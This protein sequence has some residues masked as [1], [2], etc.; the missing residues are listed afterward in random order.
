MSNSDFECLLNIVRSYEDLIRDGVGSE[1]L[2]H[3]LEVL[4]KALCFYVVD[5]RKDAILKYR[6]IYSLM[7]S[8][9]D[10]KANAGLYLAIG[11]GL[12]QCR[13]CLRNMVE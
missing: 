13:E 1:I 4:Q 8:M 10:Y 3:K 2:Y 5:I 9:P 11:Q 6:F 12:Q 7:E